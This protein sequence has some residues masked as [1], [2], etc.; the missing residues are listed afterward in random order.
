[1]DVVRV[2]VERGADIT[3]TWN[4]KTPLQIARQE[5]HPEI[6]HLLELAAQ[7]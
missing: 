7:A 4:N 1:M 6:I 2:L 5:S 3:K